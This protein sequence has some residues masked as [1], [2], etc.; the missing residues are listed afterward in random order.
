M[1]AAMIARAV[2]NAKVAV[3]DL[4]HVIAGTKERLQDDGGPDNL[5][6]IGGSFMERVAGPADLCVLKHIIH[7]WD[8]ETSRRIL[9]NCRG[10]L[11]QGGR[12]LLCEM[13]ITPGPESLPAR[14]LDVEMLVGPGGR[15]RTEAEFA[16]L[17]L[18]TGLRLNSVIETQ[19]PIRLLEAVV[20]T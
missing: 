13:L 19:T 11:N 15:E 7:D 14:V 12:V 5:E 20:H 4:P 3:F 18:S 17:F 2:P 6:A 9:G 8:D 16:R 10:A 1:L